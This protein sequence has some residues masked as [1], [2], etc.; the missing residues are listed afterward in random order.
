MRLKF[1]AADLHVRRRLDAYPNS[2][3]VDAHDR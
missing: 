1:A 2:I 3:A